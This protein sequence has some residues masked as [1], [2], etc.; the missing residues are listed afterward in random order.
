MPYNILYASLV[1]VFDTRKIQMS[2]VER[3]QA[4]HEK[5]EKPS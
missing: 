1:S 5:I 2:V 4:I 3:Q